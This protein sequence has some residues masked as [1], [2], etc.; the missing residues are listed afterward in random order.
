MEV[1]FYKGHKQIQGHAK[2]QNPQYCHK[3]PSR[4]AIRSVDGMISYTTLLTL[5]CILTTWLVNSQ[6]LSNQCDKSKCRSQGLGLAGS[7]DC[8]VKNKTSLSLNCADGLEGRIVDSV[9]IQEDGSVYYTCCPLDFNGTVRR[10]CDSSYCST[11]NN[12]GDSSNNSTCYTS[13]SELMSMTCASDRF[14]IP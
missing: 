5:G 7:S 9:S 10:E 6:S 13:S 12:S 2:S 3:H 4:L 11:P 14:S 8:W 1:P